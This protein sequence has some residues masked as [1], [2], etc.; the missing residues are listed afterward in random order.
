MND[1]VCN[2]NIRKYRDVVMET[3]E[4]YIFKASFLCGNRYFLIKAGLI[5]QIIVV[6]ILF[7]ECP[8]SAIS[9][10]IFQTCLSTI[11]LNT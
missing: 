2:R 6:A 10:P 11:A 9:M 3:T 7:Y 4:L 1:F 8:S 5:S